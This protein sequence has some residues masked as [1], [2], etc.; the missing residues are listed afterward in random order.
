M[1][2]WP[3]VIAL[4]CGTFAYRSL[5]NPSYSFPWEENLAYRDFVLLHQEAARVLADKYPEK[6]VLTAWPAIDELKNPYFGYVERP[7]EVVPVENFKRETLAQAA[8][9]KSQYELVLLYSTHG[10]LDMYE[11]ERLLDFG[12]IYSAKRN[13]QWVAILDARSVR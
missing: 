5:N 10:G 11:A 7:V 8:K 9:Q 12:I 6:R 3:L 4:A 13:G 2:L 1:Q